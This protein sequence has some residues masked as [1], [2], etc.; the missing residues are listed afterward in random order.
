MNFK[1]LLT[2]FAVLFVFTA[3][4]NIK[5]VPL[6]PRA[7]FEAAVA[8]FFAENYD[9]HKPLLTLTTYNK[10]NIVGEVS[11]INNDVIF[12]NNPTNAMI[13]KAIVDFT[14]QWLTDSKVY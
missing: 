1:L 3:C 13:L 12:G 8:K 4:S 5:D 7:E 11:Y 14:R 10:D 2:L 6:P 9:Y